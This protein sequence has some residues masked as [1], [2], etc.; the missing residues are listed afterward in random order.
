V[1]SNRNRKMP[2]FRNTNFVAES[3][4]GRNFVYLAL[5]ARLPA[6][7]FMST[8]WFIQAHTGGENQEIEVTSINQIMKDY[9]CNYHED[10]VDIFFSSVDSTTFYYKC[11]TD[12]ISSIMISKPCPHHELNKIIFEIMRLGNFIL[13]APDAIYPI[14]LSDKIEKE[15]PEGMIESLGAV[16]IAKDLA[17]FENLLDGIYG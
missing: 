1:G 10:S 9:Q 5:D 11:G 8:E 16:R 12:K 6:E 2:L 7:V 14:V 3:C 13:F 4:T 17:G 15:L